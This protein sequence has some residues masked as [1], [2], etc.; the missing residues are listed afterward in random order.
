MTKEEALERLGKEYNPKPTY[1][2]LS[3]IIGISG[4]R[5]TDDDGWTF[6]DLWEIIIVYDDGQVI[7]H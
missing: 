2:W 7:S 6:S 1:Y 3:N 4:R 5:N